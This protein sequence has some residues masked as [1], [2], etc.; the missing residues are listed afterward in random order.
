ML[1]T[2]DLQHCL[3][4]RS[5]FCTLKLVPL[6]VDLVEGR[7]HRLDSAWGLSLCFAQ[8][9]HYLIRAAYISFAFLKAVICNDY[10]RDELHLLSWDV[11]NSFGGILLALW[12]A[13]LFLQKPDVTV[14]ILNQAFSTDLRGLGLYVGAF[15]A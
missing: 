8:Y 13:I 4:V 1:T 14:A 11:V 15:R 12:Y 5:L 3:R 6:Q 2:G 9:A 7:F 10:K